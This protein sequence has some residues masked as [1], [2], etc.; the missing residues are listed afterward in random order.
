[1]KKI[2]LMVTFAIA[3]SSCSLYKTYQRPQIQTDSLFRNISLDTTTMATMVWRDLFTDPQLQMLIELGLKQNSDLNIARLRVT[4]AQATLQAARMAYTPSLAFT[5]QGTIS[6]FDNVKA[7]KS[8]QLSFSSNWE[9]DIFGKLTNSKRAAKAAFE[10]SDAYRQAVQTQ[11]IAVIANSYYMLLM[12]DSQADISARTAINWAE[13]VKTMRALMK[14]G[15]YNMAAVSQA[16]ANRLSVESSLLLLR[17]QINE[18]ENSLSVLLGQSAQS[19]KRGVLSTQNF[20]SQL[21]A[22]VPLQL[23]SNRPDVREAEF[24]LAQAFY[25]TNRARSAFYPNISLSGAAGWVNGVGQ[26]I[27]NPGKLLLSAV[28]SL[29]QPIFNKGLNKAQ[30]KIAKAKQEE[31]KIAFQQLLFNAG[32]DV[33]NALVQWQTARQQIVLDEQQINALNTTVKSTE[34]LMQYGN[35]T[36]LEVLTAKQYLLQAQLKQVSDCFSEIQ[37]VINLYHSV[38]GGLQ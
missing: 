5:P 11:L 33:N 3:M 21:Y 8:Y 9:L 17:R 20:P 28:G 37:G 4:E 16:E 23:L 18:V 10:Q 24:N 7:S 19:I 6:S 25:Y 1:M 13:N 30:L 32:A 27:V 35:T 14:A 36:Y 2:F 31:A 38:G 26:A 29:A 22:G 15:K 12:L 34:L